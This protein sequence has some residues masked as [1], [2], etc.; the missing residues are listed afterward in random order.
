MLYRHRLRDEQHQQQQHHIGLVC[1]HEFMDF[2]IKENLL[3]S[4]ALPMIAYAQ[5]H[6]LNHKITTTASDAKERTAL[7]SSFFW[8]ARTKWIRRQLPREREVSH[9]SF[10]TINTHAQNNNSTLCN[11]F[12]IAFFLSL[13]FS[14]FGF[15]VLLFLF[16]VKNLSPFSTVKI[17]CK[18]LSGSQLVKKVIR[19]SSF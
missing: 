19:K 6:K 17:E 8:D 3:K 10:R 15:F 14:S 5:A 12:W 18:K 4:E 1:R 9:K 2:Q 11:T 16:F 7:F 13:A